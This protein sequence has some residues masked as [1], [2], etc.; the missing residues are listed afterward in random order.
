MLQIVMLAT[1]PLLGF[2]FIFI[3]L[4]RLVFVLFRF[5]PPRQP[6]LFFLLF[7]FLFFCFFFFLSFFI[8]LFLLLLLLLL[9]FFFIIV[10]TYRR[11]R[12]PG[13]HG[14][15]RRHAGQG[16]PPVR[17]WRQGRGHH[18]VQG[19]AGQDRV[20]RAEAGHCL[21]ADPP[22]HAARGPRAGDAAAGPGRRAHGDGRRLGPPQP[23]QGLQGHLPHERARL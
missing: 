4:R 9:F 19:H 18:G 21:Y 15:A 13:R 11:A 22:W 14:G 17:R 3:C 20:D 2:S 8:L 12:E 23:P 6:L 7:V 1:S 10:V 16:G 5:L